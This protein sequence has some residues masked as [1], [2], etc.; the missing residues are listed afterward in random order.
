MI[1]RHWLLILL[2]LAGVWFFHV[3]YNRGVPIK[4]NAG[5]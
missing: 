1:R 5:K 3:H 2:V 4:R